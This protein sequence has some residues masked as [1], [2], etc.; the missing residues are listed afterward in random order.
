MNKSYNLWERKQHRNYKIFKNSLNRNSFSQ[1]FNQL[2]KPNNL[3]LSPLRYLLTWLMTSYRILHAP[4]RKKR[5]NSCWNYWTIREWKQRFFTEGL[6][7]GGWRKTSTNDVTARAPRSPCSRSKTQGTALAA[8]LTLSG[9]LLVS[10]LVIVARCCSTCLAKGIS[11]TKE[12]AKRYGVTPF[13]GLVLL[14]VVT[15]S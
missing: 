1:S 12:Q 7:M 3:T 5:K 2:L 6:F 11:Q 9:H 4:Q 8:T 13:W 15:A 10:I 14:V